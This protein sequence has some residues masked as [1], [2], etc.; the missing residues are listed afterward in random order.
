MNY[1]EI[2]N[3]HNLIGKRFGKLKVLSLLPKEDKTINSK[4]RCWICKC[5]CGNTKITT[6]QHL[7][8]EDKKG[9]K[10]CGCLKHRKGNQN[11]NWRG[12]KEI[13]RDY[14]SR[15]K[16]HADKSNRD[17]D[18]TIKYL[19]ELFLKQK[20]K[21]ALSGMELKFPQKHR[22]I[23]SNASLDRIDSKKGYVKD[24]IQWVDKK[25]NGMKS[26]MEEQEFIGWCK[27][28]ASCRA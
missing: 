1:N 8:S 24:N 10:S 2:K 14:F 18:I 13:P 5:D 17:C 9:T 27:K 6:T 25:V 3:K 4:Y 15:V 16:Y 7:T 12:Y 21:C 19:W 23:K 11:P 22:D 26:N 20:G 28:V